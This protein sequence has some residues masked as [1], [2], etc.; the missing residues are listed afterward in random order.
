MA[1]VSGIRDLKIEVWSF[2]TANDK[3]RFGV[4][5]EIVFNITNSIVNKKKSSQK[6][7]FFS[8]VRRGCKK[9][10]LLSAD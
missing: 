9:I 4:N 1:G 2:I 10:F 8:Y 6:S 5:G 3:L 7:Y